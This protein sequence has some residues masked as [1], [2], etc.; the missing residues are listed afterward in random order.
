MIIDTIDNLINY[1]SLNPL[2]ADVV[3]FLKSH[4]LQSLS[5]GKHPVAADKA[6][7]NIQTAKGKT[8]EE[9]TLEYHRQM[10]DIQIPLD[11]DE[12]YGYTP[13][14]DL[15]AA[16]FDE[17]KDL[18]LLPGVQPQTLFTVKKG[19]FAL[20]TPHDGHAPCISGHETFKKAIFKIKS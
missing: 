11:T 12:R 4:D 15:P 16:T 20:F 7:V 18:A 9:A 13:V 2:I 5:E 6:F 3:T 8:E 10:R 17:E 1:S 19:Q 14:A